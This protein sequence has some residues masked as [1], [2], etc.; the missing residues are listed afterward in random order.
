MNELRI[1]LAG[2][3][4]N[5]RTSAHSDFARLEAPGSPSK[6]LADYCSAAN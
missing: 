1:T 4:F 3:P 2:E 6:C 5:G